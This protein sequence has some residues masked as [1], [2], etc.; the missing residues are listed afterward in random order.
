M[1]H[2]A[3]DVSRAKGTAY[4]RNAQ[5]F[6][7]RAEIELRQVAEVRSAVIHER[8]PANDRS[9]RMFSIAPSTARRPSA[10]AHIEQFSA[11]GQGRAGGGVARALSEPDGQ[12]IDHVETRFAIK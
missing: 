11:S 10:A 3:R 1:R 9:S 8:W 2:K 12:S 7:L 5:L 4:S 6:A